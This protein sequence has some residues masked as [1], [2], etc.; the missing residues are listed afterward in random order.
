[1]ASPLETV[2]KQLADSG[3]LAPGKLENFVPPKANPTSVEELVAELVKNHHLTPFQAAQVKAG[4][5]RALILGN[6]TIL[7]KIGA[8]GM[9]QVYKAQHRRMERVVALKT[10]PAA[11]MKDPAAV[12]RFEREVKAAAKLRHT[13]IVAADDADK[14]NGIH[15][16]VMEFVDGQDLSALVKKN[17]PLSVERAVDCT[18]QAARGLEFAHKKGVIHRDIKP[19]NLLLDSEGTVKILDMGLARIQTADAAAQGE[20]TGTGAVMGTVDYMSPEQALDTKHVDARADIYSLG[21]TLFYLLLG[22]PTYEADTLT[23]KLLAHQSKPIPSLSA[24][25]AEVPVAVDAVFQR[26][27]AKQAA[28]RYQTMTEVIAALEACLAGSA[29]ALTI[30]PA[31]AVTD[32]AELLTFLRE[33]PAPTH[34]AASRKKDSRAREPAATRAGR[35]ATKSGLPVYQLAIGGMVLSLALLAAT[36]IWYWKISNAPATAAKNS[37]HPDRPQQAVGTPAPAEPA[38]AERQSTWPLGPLDE[39]FPGLVLAPTTLPG[40]KRWQVE[41][42]YPRSPVQHISYSPDGRWLAAVSNQELQARIYAVAAGGLQLAHMFPAGTRTELKGGIVWSPDSQFLAIVS[43]GDPLIRTYDI[44]AGKSGPII[45]TQG[46]SSQRVVAWSPDGK[47]LATGGY[48]G[49]NNSDVLLQPWPSGQPLLLAGHT[50]LIVALA[51][52]P[53]GSQLATICHDK[54]LR[55]WTRQGT[56]GPVLQLADKGVD[57]AWSPDGRL[58]AAAEPTATRFYMPDGSAGPVLKHESPPRWLGWSADSRWLAV[59]L[60]NNE[61]RLFDAEGKE[62]PVV[63]RNV[64][65]CA[66]H[67]RKPQLAWSE[68]NLSPRLT[69]V[70][71]PD[72]KEEFTINATGGVSFFTWSADATK[73]AI[74][75]FV[76]GLQIWD[77]ATR[78]PLEPF[79]LANLEWNQGTASIRWSPDGQRLAYAGS[80]TPRLPQARPKAIFTWRAD[81]RPD[82]IYPFAASENRQQIWDFCWSPDGE[83]L[84]ATF[85]PRQT[86]PGCTV[87]STASGDALSDLTAGLGEKEM[88]A[89]VVYSPSGLQIALGYDT[90]KLRIVATGP[91]RKVLSLDAHAGS[92]NLAWSPDGRRLASAGSSDRTV[93]LWDASDGK[94]LWS[95]EPS[96]VGNHSQAL[97]FRPDG[98]ILHV[99]R[100]GGSWLLSVD[101][102]RPVREVGPLGTHINKTEGGWSGDG[103]VFTV[104]EDSRYVC[105]Y[106]TAGWKEAGRAFFPNAKGLSR[107]S[108]DRRIAAATVRGHVGV[109]DAA[110]LAPQWSAVLLADDKQAVFSA[111]GELLY[112]I[113]DDPKALEDDLVYTVERPDGRIELLNP[114]EFA[115][116]SPT[117]SSRPSPGKPAGTKP[118]E[119]AAFQQWIKDTQALPAEKQAGAVAKKLQELNPGFDGKIVPRIEKEVVTGVTIRSE[120]VSDIAPLR[121]LGRLESFTLRSAVNQNVEINLSPLA[122]LP[123]KNLSF[124][125]ILVADLTPL[126]G[127]L[128]SSLEFGGA[129]VTDLS[130]LRGMPLKALICWH[131]GVRDL[132]PLQGMALTGLSLYNTKVSDLSPLRGMPLIELDCGSTPV[133]DLS[134]LANCK[135]LKTLKAVGT[136]VAAAEVAA[137]QKALP[138]CQIKWGDLAKPAAAPQPSPIQ[139]A[140]A[141]TWDSPAFAQ[142]MKDTQALPTDKQ[143]AAVAKKLQELNPGFD[144]IIR[145]KIENGVVTG[146]DFFTNSVTDISPVRALAGLKTLACWGVYVGTGKLSDLSPLAGM[147]LTKLSCQR[148][149]LLTDLTP[150]VG[151]PLTALNCQNVPADLSCVATLPLEELYCSFQPSLHAKLLQSMKTLKRI[152]DKPVQQFWA[153]L[154]GEQQLEAVVKELRAKN[155]KFTSNDWGSGKVSGGK[156]TEIHLPQPVLGDLSPLSKLRDLSALACGGDSAN[157]CALSD[158][159]PLA[160]LPITELTVR[161]TDVADLSPL[162]GMPLAKLICDSNSRI[163]DLSPLGGL[164][165]KIVRCHS[166]AVADLK[167]LAGITNLESLNVQKTKVTAAQ[168]A[169][170]QK[171][172]P[173]CKIEWDDPAKPKTP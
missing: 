40:V 136:K 44:P 168:V 71:L 109:W 20:L 141:K 76:H 148:N 151:L 13:N 28:E 152:N 154:P 166:T 108:D 33:M 127:M 128:L 47:L 169:A 11:T 65:M 30:Q 94:L 160:G 132:S 158:L 2:V 113:P 119:T 58:L 7:E 79:P 67:S 78:S 23:A 172:L 31:A 66:W 3:I 100:Y 121:A 41:A 12:A 34:P 69:A 21:C 125:N 61:V 86:P 9:G 81:G 52:S 42:A 133:A 149:P 164:P 45:T 102:G 37:T 43:A 147:K 73:L 124:G 5:V 72:G 131:T 75:N 56:A 36:G 103:Q 117:P 165:L 80:L 129:K 46:T 54:T 130:P 95:T 115:R 110:T 99:H 173:N 92:V 49:K 142:W 123:L 137:L 120:N 16:L 145:P 27:V 38:A 159:R 39:S 138:N 90:G 29:H 19:A 14:A 82:R 96:T 143:L 105:N 98:R 35:K 62:S 112:S 87:V 32:E 122:G 156:V 64:F 106:G 10:L 163:S 114:S 83:Q 77:L 53:D 68:Q 55:F 97:A 48:I 135:N 93:R 116:L 57:L 126:Q 150:I 157:H 146:L 101:D 84:A 15:F 25:R 140:G 6:Y 59:L 74:H 167:P 107:S 134:P 1:M 24:L 153:D 50:S 4:K 17:G 60:A 111:A 170:L 89:H 161:F 85:F 171:A 51:W 18:L 26:M 104:I 162:K 91:A 8:G 155:P 70:N 144:G 63:R 88:P 118:W 139:A 22:K